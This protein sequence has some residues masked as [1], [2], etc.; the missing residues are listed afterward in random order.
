MAE[1]PAPNASS[2]NAGSISPTPPASA[3]LLAYA[4]FGTAAVVAL[5]SHGFP[6]AAP[7]M[8]LEKFPPAISLGVTA[9]ILAAGILWS[10]WKTRAEA[11]A[12][13]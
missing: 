6:F 13:L 1:F 10:V 9:A 8:G 11:R 12:D 5:L 2:S 7:L 4:L 3:G